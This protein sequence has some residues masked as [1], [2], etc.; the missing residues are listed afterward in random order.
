[1][2]APDAAYLGIDV[3][4]TFLKGA[5]ID[6]TGKVVARLHE[7]IRKA[8]S[9]ELL[10]QLASAVETLEKGVGPAVAVG[11]GLPGIVEMTRAACAARPTCPPS[12]G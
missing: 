7:P 11:V 9:A 5:R 8:S 1:M 10:A 4:G 2:P 6:S 3:G 12:T